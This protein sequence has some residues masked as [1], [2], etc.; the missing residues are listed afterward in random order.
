MSVDSSFNTTGTIK[1]NAESM[2]DV[3]FKISQKE[4]INEI[5]TTVT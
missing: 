5:S 3:F 2:C 1:K 4:N